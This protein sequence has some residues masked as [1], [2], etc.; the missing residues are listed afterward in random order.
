MVEGVAVIDARVGVE[1]HV[2]E[3]CSEVGEAVDDQAVVVDGDQEVEGG[4]LEFGGW[5][6]GTHVEVEGELEGV[7]AD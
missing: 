3:D 2:T 5:S 4:G 7:V 6:V 1:V